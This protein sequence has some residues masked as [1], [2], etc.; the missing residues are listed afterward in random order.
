MNINTKE[1]LDL[2]L[3]EA[4]ELIQDVDGKSIIEDTEDF[5]RTAHTIKSS[6]KIMGFNNLSELSRIVE[7]GF[8]K[9]INN[10]VKLN[11]SIKENLILA[12]NVLKDK[13]REIS[14]KKKDIDQKS[15]DNQ[16][17]RDIKTFIGE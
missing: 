5:R 6:S 12:F 3:D 4:N 16:P 17:I 15:L 2:F 7:Y 10:E 14:E 8:K 13:V 1:Y 11:E 9:I